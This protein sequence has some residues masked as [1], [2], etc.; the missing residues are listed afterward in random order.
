VHC[1]GCTWQFQ[2][3]CF[4]MIL[5]MNLKK[6]IIALENCNLIILALKIMKQILVYFLRPDL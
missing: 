4:K 5:K 3:R 2:S 6:D 1:A